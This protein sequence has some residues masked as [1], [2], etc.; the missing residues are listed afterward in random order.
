[1][2]ELTRRRVLAGT[3]LAG[4]STVAGCLDGLNTGGDT[5][6]QGV[7]S[8]FFVFGAVAAAV[9]GDATDADV[10]VPVGQ[11]GHGWEPGPR[12][13][14]SIRDASLLVHG[15]RGFQPWVDDIRTDLRADGATV[16]TVDASA[17]VDLLPLGEGHDH[18]D[19]EEHTETEHHDDEEHHDGHGGEFDPH[20]W[21]DPLRVRTAVDTVREALVE[22]D[23]GN[24]DTYDANATAYRERLDELH[25]DLEATV[26]DSSKGMLLVAGH[27]AFQYLGDR[28]GLQ[29]E[30]LTGISPDSRPTARDIQRAQEVIE[31]HDLRY[32]CADPLESQ[33]AA[34]QLVQETDATEVLPLTAL[35]GLHD[36]WAD[37]DWSYLDVVENVNRPTLERALEG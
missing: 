19:G 20:F 27:D 12:V 14:E 35:P 26:A 6:N 24:T 15:M 16:A 37:R 13:R 30:A 3:G 2:R 32:I 22:V 36:D 18:G 9:A 17:D 29:I 21:L 7:Q 4:L 33:R 8:S 11:H 28:Y 23:P 25:A 5:E 10:L 1:M 34:E 31:T